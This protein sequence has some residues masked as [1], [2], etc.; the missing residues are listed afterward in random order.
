MSLRKFDAEPQKGIRSHRAIALTLVMSKW[1]A[2]SIITMP[3]GGQFQL[4]GCACVVTPLLSHH[5]LRWLGSNGPT[6]LERTSRISPPSSLSTRHILQDACTRACGATSPTIS[7][8][9]Q[10]VPG[11]KRPGPLKNFG[12]DFIT[13]ALLSNLERMLNPSRLSIAT[14][15]KTV[16]SLTALVETNLVS[17]VL[18]NPK[19][20]GWPSTTQ[21]TLDP[22][23]QGQNRTQTPQSRNQPL[24]RKRTQIRN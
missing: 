16:Q 9:E 15:R 17:V 11:H 7:N 21:R 13:A 6:A 18:T 20:L 10:K 23:T 5:N 4:C 8:L 22:Q 24:G 2:S 12:I 14:L 19:T 1:Y 3:V